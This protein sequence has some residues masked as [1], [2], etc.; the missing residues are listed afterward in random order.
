MSL[1]YNN[2]RFKSFRM[3]ILAISAVLLAGLLI[4]S[5][6]SFAA[7][8]DPAGLNDSHA[9]AQ[10]LYSLRYRH[11]DLP[12]TLD[13]TRECHPSA[14]HSGTFTECLSPSSST[15]ELSEDLLIERILN[16][17]FP[18]TAESSPKL[19]SVIPFLPSSEETK[20]HAALFSHAQSFDE[21]MQLILHPLT[22]LTQEIESSLHSLST[23]QLGTG[24]VFI[25][26]VMN[27]REGFLALNK[28]VIESLERTTVG[29]RSPFL[30]QQKA[31]KHTQLVSYK[32]WEDQLRLKINLLSEL[33]TVLRQLQSR[34][35]LTLSKVEEHELQLH[36]D[37]LRTKRYADL[38]KTPIEVPQETLDTEAAEI[39]QAREALSSAYKKTHSHLNEGFHFLRSALADSLSSPHRSELA[40]AEEKKREEEMKKAQ[41]LEHLRKQVQTYQT[42]LEDLRTYHLADHEPSHWKEVSRG[43]EKYVSAPLK[44]SAITATSL[45]LSASSLRPRSV[46]IALGYLAGGAYAAAKHKYEDHIEGKLHKA[47]L[48][49]R[50]WWY[51]YNPSYDTQIHQK[52]LT[53]LQAQLKQAESPTPQTAP[54]PPP[55]TETPS[56]ASPVTKRKSGTS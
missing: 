33:R 2:S 11:S 53:K 39:I 7:E 40:K 8:V 51:S 25:R 37:S 34:S 29:L 32:N 16:Y 45:K 49:L 31:P 41:A 10:Y 48:D 56:Q 1:I 24:P 23:A 55:R 35:S 47:W 30:F 18:S 19:T 6:I 46:F 3:A 12:P 52:E 13:K 38:E 27:T 9:L 5:S 15:A 17:F 44:G 42:F 21:L 36:E 43:F 28:Q 50:A 26:S 4:P 54:K 22:P 20:A 14:S